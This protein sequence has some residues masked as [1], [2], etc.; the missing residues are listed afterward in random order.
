MSNTSGDII[1]LYELG[2]DSGSTVSKQ[3][4]ETFAYA[5]NQPTV[6]EEPCISL[7]LRDLCHNYYLK[8]PKLMSIDIE[9]YGYAPLM[10]ND[11]T[12]DLCVP[13]VIIAEDSA[14]NTASGMPPIADLLKAKNYSKREM[15]GLNTIYIHNEHLEFYI[16]QM[17]EGN[18]VFQEKFNLISFWSVEP[19]LIGVAAPGAPLNSKHINSADIGAYI[20]YCRETVISIP[21]IINEANFVSRTKR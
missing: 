13:E 18:R 7:N 12:N 9:G 6:K 2:E 17:N 15:I 1:L 16:K 21:D 20:H 19:Q 14:Y 3:A 8:K 10:T 11:W 4:K 5:M